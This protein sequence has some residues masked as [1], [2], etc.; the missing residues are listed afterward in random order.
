MN[1]TSFALALKALSACNKLLLVAKAE[2][3]LLTEVMYAEEQW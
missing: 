2:P 1:K 3:V